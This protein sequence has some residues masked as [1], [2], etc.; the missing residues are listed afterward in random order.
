MSKFGKVVFIG[1]NQCPTGYMLRECYPNVLLEKYV[2]SSDDDAL[3]VSIEAE[4]EEKKLLKFEDLCECLEKARKI[5]PDMN[6]PI[7]VDVYSAD[8]S[9]LVLKIPFGPEKEPEWDKM[10]EE[11]LKELEVKILSL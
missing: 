10:Y 9:P 2:R 5:V 7:H 1:I 8:G 6:V 3:K 4:F 11:K